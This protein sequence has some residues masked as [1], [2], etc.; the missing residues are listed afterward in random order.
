M[1]PTSYHHLV[2]TI[3]MSIL[4]V[5]IMTAVITA[6]NTGIDE[7]FLGRWQHAFIL[8]WPI[9]FLVILFFSPKVGRLTEKLCS[10]K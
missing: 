6:I 9:A 10:K 4:M 2:R 3:L 8:A 1:F 5:F 7:N